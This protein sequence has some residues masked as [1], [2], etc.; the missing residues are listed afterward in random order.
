MQVCARPALNLLFMTLLGLL[1]S[2]GNQIP[3]GGCPYEPIPPRNVQLS[4]IPA[5]A[6]V[7]GVSKGDTSNNASASCSTSAECQN[8]SIALP[9]AT[10]ETYSITVTASGY[11]SVSKSFTFDRES[12]CGTLTPTTVSF[13]LTPN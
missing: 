3:C 13:T 12:C 10:G 1:G 11:K 7:T 6:T 2:C 8:L 4:P 9:I 5:Q